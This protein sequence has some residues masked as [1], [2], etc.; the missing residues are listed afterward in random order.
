MAILNTYVWPNSEIAGTYNGE[1][2][3]LKSWLQKRIA[4][5]DANVQ[6]LQN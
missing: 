1:V 6:T 5:I 3:F 4:W 2:A